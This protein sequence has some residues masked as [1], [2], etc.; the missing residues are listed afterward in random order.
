VADATTIALRAFGVLAVT[1]AMIGV[2]GLV[3]YAF[4]RRVRE[5]GIRMP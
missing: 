3:C 5:I 1:P 2:P 4:V